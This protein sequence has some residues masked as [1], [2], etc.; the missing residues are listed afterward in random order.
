MTDPT[1]LTK[2]RIE[3]IIKEFGY[4]SKKEFVEE[5]VREKLKEL[6]KLQF[7]SISEKIRKGLA[8]KGI[9]PEDILKEI[10]S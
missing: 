5:A 3:E 8:K 6:R 4:S 9:K 1:S 7:F 2:K 10:K